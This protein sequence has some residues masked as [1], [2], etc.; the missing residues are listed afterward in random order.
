MLNSAAAVIRLTTHQLLGGRRRILTLVSWLLPVGVA[1]LLRVLLPARA[2]ADSSVGYGS[3]LIGVY[4]SILVPFVA[5]YWGSSVLTDEVEGKT[6]VYLWT[7]PA[8]RARIM[9]MKFAV[10]LAWFMVLLLLSLTATY[11]TLAWGGEQPVRLHHLQT[12]LWDLR[13]L[14]LGGL[15]YAAV[16]FFLAS[17]I[18]KPLMASLLYFYTIDFFLSWPIIP[19]YLKLLSVHHYV[20]VLSTRDAAP[21]ADGPARFLGRAL[22][23]LVEETP[24]TESQAVWTLV[25][26]GLAFLIAGAL[27]T[28]SREFLGDDSARNQ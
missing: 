9:V 25:A 12:V 13:A 26:A 3:V 22:E 11:L 5:V 17:L 10:A 6:L 14:S 24:T 28:R 4:A 7:R 1:L 18:R 19:G 15:T 27:L 16:A 23:K 20:A 21:E 8:G 2:F